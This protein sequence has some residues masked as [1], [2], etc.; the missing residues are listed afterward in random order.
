MNDVALLLLRF[1]GLGLALG[2]GLGKLMNLAAGNTGFIEGVAKMGLPMPGLFGW[3]AAISEV[4]GGLLVFFGLGTRVAAAFCAIT[5]AVAALGRHHAH[6]Q[7]LVKVH[8]LKVPPENLQ[9]WGNPEL[10]L[11]YLLP[12]AALV[13]LGGG[14]YALERMFRKGGRR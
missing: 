2:H 9:A 4:V 8:L 13:L 3:A 7:L 11:M 12:F 5:M 1:A 6:D 14:Q 10:A